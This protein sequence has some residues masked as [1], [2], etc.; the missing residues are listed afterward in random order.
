MTPIDAVRLTPQT[1]ARRPAIGMNSDIRI[2][3][4]GRDSQS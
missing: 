1:S 2:A 4:A 3:V